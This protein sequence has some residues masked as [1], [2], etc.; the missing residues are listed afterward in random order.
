[1]NLEGLSEVRL[2]QRRELGEVVFGFETRNKYEVQ[3]GS[4]RPLGFAAEQGKGF[5]GFLLRSWLGHWRVFDLLLFDLQ[6]QVVARAHHPFRFF[7][8]RLEVYDA[9]GT[10]VGAL[11]QRWA[12]FTK[13]FDVEDANGN[14][15]LE[16]RSGFF[17]IW[18]FPFFRGGLEVAKVEKRWG[19]AVRE[20]FTDA[21]T[22]RVSFGQAG[23][24]AK[25]RLL[26]VAAGLFIDLQYF[27]RQA[28]S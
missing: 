1:M 17:R 20:L 24:S 11:Q 10:F 25:E 14:V 6:R 4:G 23:L 2:S 12:F 15:L 19:G 22:F 7:F 13:R 3:D 5:F 28:G 16:M 26:L 21:D 18:A 8:Q 9:A 27:E